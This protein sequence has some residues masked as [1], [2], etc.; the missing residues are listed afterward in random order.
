M[1]FAC[2]FAGATGAAFMQAGE[3]DRA[4]MAAAVT[5]VLVLVGL[6]ARGRRWWVA[7]RVQGGSAASSVAKRPPGTA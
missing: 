5:A 1:V 4:G 7:R 2:V 6:G 3:L